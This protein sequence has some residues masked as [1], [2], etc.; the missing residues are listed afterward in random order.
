MLTN[1]DTQV[2]QDPHRP[3][4]HFLPEK[5]WM[6]DP[7]GLIQW[8]GQYHMFY[9]YNPHGAFHGTIHWGHAISRDLVHWEHLPI[10][11]APTPDGV[12]KD[13]CWSG[14]AVN[15]NGAPTLLYTGV[16]P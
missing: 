2:L 6:N 14:C 4:F 1:R 13:G 15:N 9:Q 10:A 11:L 12:D 8:K 5:H 16:Y 7:N 3:A